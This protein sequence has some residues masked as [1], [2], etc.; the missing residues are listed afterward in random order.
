MSKLKGLKYH[1]TLSLRTLHNREEIV[2]LLTKTQLKYKRKLC[3][4]A[5]TCSW[6]LCY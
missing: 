1:A 2:A 3:D 5:W 4:A 6:S